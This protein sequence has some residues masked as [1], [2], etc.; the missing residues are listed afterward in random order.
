M[1]CSTPSP[2]GGLKQSGSMMRSVPGEAAGCSTSQRTTGWLWPASVLGTASAVRRGVSQDGEG[3]RSSRTNSTRGRPRQM[4]L[5]HLE[6]EPPPETRHDNLMTG[7]A[8]AGAEQAEHSIM[9]N[10]A[11]MSQGSEACRPPA[12]YQPLPVTCAGLCPTRRWIHLGELVKTEEP[13]ACSGGIMT[14]LKSHPGPRAARHHTHL[15]LD[16]SLPT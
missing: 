3:E 10:P 15:S 12:F 7:A 14:Q 13:Q 5:S 9:G 4:L 11:L 6:A 8:A 16:K 1:D 2:E